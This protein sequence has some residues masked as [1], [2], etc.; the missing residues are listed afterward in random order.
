MRSL[1]SHPSAVIP[2]LVAWGMAVLGILGAGALY[3]TPPGQSWLLPSCPI[4]AVSGMYCPGC[5]TAR[6]LHALLHGRLAEAL[7]SNLLLV[8]LLPL[9]AGLALLLF[10]DAVRDNRVRDLRLPSWAAFGLVA[11]VVVFTILR[12]LPDSLPMLG[13]VSYLA[14]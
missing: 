10:V 6:A 8:A 2:R 14:P 3:L 12:N 1:E 5:G 9:L 11:I 7:D 4:H 13:W